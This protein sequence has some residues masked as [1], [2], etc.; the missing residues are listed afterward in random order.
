MTGNAGTL[1]CRDGRIDALDVSDLPLFRLEFPRSVGRLARLCR[2]QLGMLLFDRPP[3]EI[4]RRRWACRRRLYRLR[5]R[6]RRRRSLLTDAL[7]IVVSDHHD[8][9]FGFLGSDDL[10]R[11]LRPFAIAALIVTKEIGNSGFSEKA[12]SSPYASQSALASP[13]TTILTAASLRGVA[14]GA[15]E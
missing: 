14:G 8:D 2:R 11:Y 5:V 10:A 7:T 1:Q 15:W 12:S 6:W 4:R 3:L 9:E 13:I